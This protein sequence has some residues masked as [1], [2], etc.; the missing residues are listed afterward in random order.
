MPHDDTDAVVQGY[1]DTEEVGEPS[2][3]REGWPGPVG[4][5]FGEYLRQLRESYPERIGYNRPMKMRLTALALIACLGSHD[6]PITSGYYSELERS[7]ALP[8]ESG[9][10][11]EAVAKCLELTS[12][13]V[14]GLALQLS[15][16]TE[17]PRLGP[18]FA[19][20]IFEAAAQQLLPPPP[21]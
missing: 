20:E 1:Q 19:R 21:N 14:R 15:Y 9:R 2:P 8:K 7:T 10:F 12:T 6:Y 4:K 3:A 5:S 17:L 18:R 13:E 16:E 11:L